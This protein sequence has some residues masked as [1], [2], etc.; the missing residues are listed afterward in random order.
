MSQN[1]IRT[2]LFGIQA[3]PAV[4][5]AVMHDVLFDAGSNPVQPK[6]SFAPKTIRVHNGTSVGGV[7][8]A[9][10]TKHTELNVT[11]LPVFVD[12]LP[13]Y[14]MLL[15]G[16][17][18]TTTGTVT[19]TYKH[20]F[21]LGPTADPSVGAFQW[22]NGI[23]WREALA[24]VMNT[25][26]WTQSKENE[27]RFDFGMIGAASA[28]PAGGDPT[29][30]AIENAYNDV[31]GW[32]GLDGTIEAAPADFVSFNIDITNNRVNRWT[33]RNTPSPQRQLRGLTDNKLQAVADLVAYSGS[34]IEKYDNGSLLGDMKLIYTLNEAAIGTGGTAHPTVTFEA[35]RCL[36]SDASVTEDG[37]ATNQ[38]VDVMADYNATDATSMTI[39]VLN[40]I[41]G[42]TYVG[43]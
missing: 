23:Y 25:F 9:K 8:Q 4:L 3:N 17:P 26:K 27:P 18:T 13:W 12:M 5:P 38:T 32:A 34:Y 15:C 10:N 21:K 42:T 28:P 6:D 37:Y 19:G 35:R 24:L 14:L 30:P 33:G 22:F 40:D 29:L 39:E 43:S 1:A 36:I 31:I 16:P 11:N 41:V 20:L 7:V 2:L